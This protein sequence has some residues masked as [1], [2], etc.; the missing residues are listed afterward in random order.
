MFWEVIKTC[1]SPVAVAA[2]LRLS[3]PLIIGSIGGCFNEKTSTG[4]LAYECFMLTGA[5]FGAYGSY[6]T[7]SPL[8]GS[9]IAILSGLVLAIIYGSLVY[10]LNCNAIIVSVA[11]NSAAW[12]LTTLML[13]VVWNTRGQ[14]NDPSIVSYQNLNWEFLKKF[15][16][17]DMMFNNNILM[18]YLAFI[19]T[20]IGH[21]VMYKTP[22]GLRLRGVGINSETAQAAGISV[23]KYRWICL[24]IMGASMGLAGSYMPLCGMS[25]FSENMTRGRGFLCLTSTLVGKGNPIRTMLIALLFGYANAMTLVL[26]TY[27]MPT[28]IISMLPYVM[29]LIVLLSVGLKNFKGGIDISSDTL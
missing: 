9:L 18:V 22:F 16:I 27:N 4:N 24:L 28:Q 21:I 7:G 14:F 19:F 25:L 17:L 26:S 2:A 13:V 6:L 10:H 11:Y 23:R 3:C 1:L 8:M 20:F 15:P 5:F 12:A 29:V